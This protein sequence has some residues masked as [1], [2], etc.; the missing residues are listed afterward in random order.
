MARKNSGY[1][2]PKALHTLSDKRC[3]EIRRYFDGEGE[4]HNDPDVMPEHPD[5]GIYVL[6]LASGRS[7]CRCCG[8]R[9]KKGDYA[10]HFNYDFVGCGSWTIS[11][12][13]IHAEDCEPV[14]TPWL[15]K[16]TTLYR[17]PE[18]DTFWREFITKED[19]EAYAEHL[20]EEHDKDLYKPRK[21]RFMTEKVFEAVHK[22]ELVGA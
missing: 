8:Q 17:T 16:I 7:R 3:K 19:A 5:E 21:G 22:N 10:I 2:K 20:Q 18:V 9:I 14:E 11:S 4:Y 1:R 6:K 12:C 15:I 13:W